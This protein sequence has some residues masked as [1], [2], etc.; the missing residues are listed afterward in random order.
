MTL[1][2]KTRIF[3]AVFAIAF[4]IDFLPRLEARQILTSDI[5]SLQSVVIASLI[6]DGKFEEAISASMNVIDEASNSNYQLAVIRGYLQISNALS[7]LGKYK[8]SLAYL[9][10]AQKMKPAVSNSNIY[11]RIQEGIARNYMDLEL[12]KQA[13]D[14]YTE[15]IA[16]YELNHLSNKGLLSVLLSNKAAAFSRNNEIDSALFYQHRAI[17]VYPTDIKY[18]SMAYHHLILRNNP[19]SAEYYLNK[20]K[21]LIELEGSSKYAKSILLLNYG[22]FFKELGEFE[23]ALSY[24]LESL[25]IS[26]EIKRVR[27]MEKAYKFISDTYMSLGEQEKSYEYLRNYSALNDSINRLNNEAVNLVIGQFFENQEQKYQS[28]TH[29]LNL[30]IIGVILISLLILGV[31]YFY[32]EKKKKERLKLVKQKNQVIEEKEKESAQLKQQLNEAFAEVADLAIQNSPLFLARFQEVY[33][34]FCE[35]LNAV[36]P[37]LVNT[38]LTLCAMIWL[39]FTSKEIAQ[40]TFVQPK[41]VQIKKY[42]L[43]KKLG[44]PTDQDIYL[45]MK[46]F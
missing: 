27:E 19:D 8:E 23:T 9:D 43:R 22:N 44:I 3:K 5:D 41:T 35:K 17:A 29:R 30:I 18:I 15:A 14:K 20:A 33:P 11:V 6:R 12:Y 39:N 13:I 21:N 38:E 25:S 10:L 45:W 7:A 26:K 28:D 37:N 34:E 40:Y 4:I 31:F 36:N 16:E 2:I 24:Y 1:S 46:G 42:R 32:Y